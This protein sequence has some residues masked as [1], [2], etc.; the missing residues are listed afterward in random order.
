M[1]KQIIKLSLPEI[2]VIAF[3]LLSFFSNSVKGQAQSLPGQG[4]N[5]LALDQKAYKTLNFGD[6]TET[7]KH[8]LNE[9]VTDANGDPNFD[10][11]IPY[12]E[13]IFWRSLFDTDAEYEPYKYDGNTDSQSE[14]FNSLMNYFA[15]RGMTMY[16]QQNSASHQ[17]F[18][19]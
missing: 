2:A 6:T 4:S 11:I 12:H 16:S 18:L 1:N 7:V 8:K 14:K 9:I 3:L 17:G 15:S 19:H 10:N 5:T 13:E